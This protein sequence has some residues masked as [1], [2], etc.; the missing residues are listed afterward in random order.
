MI[1]KEEYEK[2]LVIAFI[3]LGLI[4][5]NSVAYADNQ[6]TE[7][8]DYEGVKYTLEADGTATIIR[9]FSNNKSI[10][11]PDVID[12]HDV[13]GLGNEAFDCKN[14]SSIE[15]PAS[16]VRVDGNPFS[17]CQ[18]LKLINVPPEHTT[19]ATIDGVLFDKTERRLVS[20]PRFK[21]V[22]QYTIPEGIKCIGAYAFSR[23]GAEE[24]IL[25]E[26][27][28]TIDDLAFV[29]ANVDSIIISD[30]VKSIGMNPFCGYDGAIVISSNHPV[31]QLNDGVLFDKS[32]GCLIYYPYS[33]SLFESIVDKYIIPDGTTRIGEYAFY[34]CSNIKGIV[35]PDSVTSIGDYAFANAF[36]MERI[37]L[38]QNLTII[39]ER[40]FNGCSNLESIE[41]PNSVTTIQDYAF[42]ECEHLKTIDV[43]DSVTSFGRGMFSWCC[44]LE[45]VTLPNTL[46]VI[47]DSTFLQCGS[48][49]SVVV[50]DGVKGIG[51]YAFDNCKLLGQITIPS[52]VT[53]LGDNVFKGCGRITVTVDYDSYAAKYCENNRITYTY[54]TDQSW[55]SN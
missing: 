47:P 51:D 7:I 41:I 4:I 23:A 6:E 33:D 43:P 19:L 8:Y 46:E 16:I 24:I 3:L 2:E 11:I 42:D 26:S 54:A 31:L 18:S 44:D 25:P 27:V 38:P 53:Y 5:S 9:F 50:P 21:S 40:A 22:R 55:L 15:I 1:G 49:T 37:N 14:I 28:T 10:N 52:S 17:L 12:G 20:Y 34:Y 30:S 48:L 29:Y 39:G 13:T 36:R 45:S 32:S 35:I